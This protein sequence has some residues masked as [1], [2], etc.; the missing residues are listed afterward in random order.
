MPGFILHLG[1]TVQCSHAGTATPTAPNPRV[2]VSGQPVV[3]ISCPYVVA[4]CAFPPPPAGN[5][6]CV[7]A[8]FVTSATRVLAGGVPVLLLDSQAICA[9]TGTPLLIV[10]T[11]TKATAQ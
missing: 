9:P 1:A 11:Q 10:S 7:T 2:M 4:G 5:G 6:P 8:Q 3:T